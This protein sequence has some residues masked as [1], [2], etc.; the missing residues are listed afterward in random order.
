MN[1]ERKLQLV[2]SMLYRNCEEDLW[3]KVVSGFTRPDSD[4]LEIGSGSGA[5]QQNQLYPRAKSVFGIDLDERVLANPFLNEA[6]VASAYDLS[7]VVGDRRFNVIY[8]HMVAEHIENATQF[9]EEQFRSLADHGVIIHSTASGKC[10][11]SLLNRVVPE[12]VKNWLIRHMGSGREAKDIFHTFYNLNSRGDVEKLAKTVGF[13]YAIIGQDEPPGYLRRSILLMLIYAAVFKP[14]SALIPSVKP[15]FI[16]V[17][18]R[19]KQDLERIARLRS[20]NPALE[21]GK[22][23]L[24]DRR[25]EGRLGV[26]RDLPRVDRLGFDA[27]WVRP[28]L[29]ML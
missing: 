17:I 18:A 23:G 21:H 27:A 24:S 16:V 4:V 12:R 2:R 15:T 11:S 19:S 26:R 3:F 13:E 7:S 10:P 28:S 9:L 1:R 22:V 25:Q 20:R 8:S 29:G 5:G 6:R 14:L